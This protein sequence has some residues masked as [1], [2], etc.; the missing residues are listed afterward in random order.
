MK[1]TVK[2]DINHA[3]MINGSTALITAACNEQTP[4]ECFKILI[5]AGA[6]VNDI[7]NYNESAFAKLS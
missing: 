1:A 6:N 4:F 5:E 2:I 7:D 3:H